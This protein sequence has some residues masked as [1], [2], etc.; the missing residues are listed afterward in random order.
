MI[1]DT[2]AAWAAGFLDGEG[3]FGISL[4]GDGRANTVVAATQVDPRPLLRL[5]EFFGGSLSNCIR[6]SRG[7]YYQWSLQGNTKVER[8]LLA[9]RP[10]LSIKGE[11][12]EL[13]LA[14]IE[15]VHSEPKKRTGVFIS[16][17]GLRKR[18]EFAAAIKK[19]NKQRGRPAV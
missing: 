9:V 18:I 2:D 15:L 1:L 3:H 11:Q 13:M 12:T 17:E 6:G 10:Y 14:L 8:L 4:R 16:D 19:I 5:K 7:G